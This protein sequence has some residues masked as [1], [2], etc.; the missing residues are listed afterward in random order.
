MKIKTLACVAFMLTSLTL[1]AQLKANAISYT[2]EADMAKLWGGEV[3][4]GT[5]A[6]YEVDTYYSADKVRTVVRNIKNEVGLTI[7]ERLYDQNSRDEYNINHNEHRI[8]L[9]KDQAFSPK[10]TGQQKTILG[11]PCKEYTFKNYANV[12]FSLWVT[13]KL[14]KNVCPGGNF[15]VKGTA[16]EIIGSNGLHFVA[17]DASGSG[18]VNASFFNPPDGYQQEV[19]NPPVPEA[20]RK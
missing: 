6:K 20:K 3:E 5:V 10:A 16:L 14:G 13:E 19:I 2:L 11:Y 18:E 9:K 1:Q 17:V 12:T 4:E 15:S 7:M 8:L